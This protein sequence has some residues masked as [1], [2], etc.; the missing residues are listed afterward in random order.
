MGRQTAPVV[1][2][3]DRIVVV[4]TADQRPMRLSYP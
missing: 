2:M 3:V 1:A 4:T